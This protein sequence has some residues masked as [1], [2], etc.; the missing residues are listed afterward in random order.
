MAEQHEEPPIPPAKQGGV[1]GAPPREPSDSRFVICIAL[2]LRLFPC[3]LVPG[4]KKRNIFLLLPISCPFHPSA[5]ATLTI[6]SL[7]QNFFSRIL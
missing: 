4:F 1:L 6:Y 3:F 5:C 7:F 2:K